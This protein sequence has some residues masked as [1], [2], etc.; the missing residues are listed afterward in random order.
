VSTYQV[1]GEAKGDAVAYAAGKAARLRC[2]ISRA[3]LPS[4][5]YIMSRTLYIRAGVGSI[6]K[7]Q[8]RIRAQRKAM[9]DKRFFCARLT[10]AECTEIN[11]LA[12]LGWLTQPI[13]D[14]IGCTR[15][16]IEYYSMTHGVQIRKLSRQEVGKMGSAAARRKAEQ[17]A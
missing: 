11:R 8:D 10:E 7:Y 13:A 15:Q 4:R 16:A 14:A 9:Q 17:A 12:A 2:P 1:S 6:N 5:E 3:D